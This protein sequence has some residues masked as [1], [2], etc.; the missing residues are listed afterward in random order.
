M[1]KALILI[2]IASIMLAALPFTGFGAESEDNAVFVTVCNGSILVASEKIE[3]TDADDDGTLTI[4]DALIL[5][6]DKFYNGNAQAGYSYASGDYGLYITKLWG[7]TGGS[8]GYYVNDLSAFS[9][10]DP[11]TDGDRI[12][13]FVYTDQQ[14]WSDTYCYFDKSSLDAVKGENITLTL[15]ASGFDAS[16][17]PTTY[18]VSGAVITVNGQK[19]EYVTDKDGKVTITLSSAGRA[20]ISAVSDSA[21]L[22]PAV[23]KANVS[24]NAPTGDSAVFIAVA[25]GALLLSAL[26]LHSLRKQ[27]E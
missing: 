12:T 20:V 1:N 9:L 21:V 7:D 19:T 10:T 4:N 11:V 15:L 13:A 26:Y 2:L 27:Y 8:F 23:C 16:F 17:N 5:T 3:V 25:G 24:E 14:T 22:V 6:H 18:P